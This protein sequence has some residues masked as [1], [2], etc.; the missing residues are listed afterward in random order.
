MSKKEISEETE[1]AMEAF[2][3]VLAYLAHTYNLM[4]QGQLNAPL[5]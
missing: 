1:Q 2:R 5:N 4:K 3:E